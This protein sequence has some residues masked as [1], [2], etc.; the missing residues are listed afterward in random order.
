MQVL[1]VCACDVRVV[2]ERR[3]IKFNKPQQCL[4]SG[5]ETVSAVGMIYVCW[6]NFRPGCDVNQMCDL[7]K[8]PQPHPP[9]SIP[10]PRLV[11]APFGKE[12]GRYIGEEKGSMI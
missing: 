6:M 5:P 9:T 10:T 7:Y 4:R 12:K 1:Y 2:G 11:L 8:H 3:C